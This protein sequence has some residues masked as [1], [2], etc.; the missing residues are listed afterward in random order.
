MLWKPLGLLM[1]IPT[2]GAALLITWQ[3]RGIKSELLHNIAVIFWILANAYWMVTEFFSKNDN[4]RYYAIIPFTLGI[5][6]IA[7]YYL[8]LKFLKKKPSPF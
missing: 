6:V 3:T 1:I 8:G 4:L 5:I 7:Y 2:L